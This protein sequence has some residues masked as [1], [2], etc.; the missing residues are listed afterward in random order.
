LM[1][2]S[3]QCPVDLRGGHQLTLFND[4]HIGVNAN[5]SP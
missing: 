3:L 5:T 4:S 1:S 2:K